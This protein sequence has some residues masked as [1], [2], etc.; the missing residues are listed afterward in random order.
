MKKNNRAAR[1]ACFLIPCFDRRSLPH[2]HVKFSYLKFWRQRELAAVNL[3]LFPLHE[4]SSYQTSE[5]AAHL[6]CTTWSTWNNRKRLNLTQS[7][8]LMW[9]FCC[10]CRRS[11]L[12]SLVKS[13]CTLSWWKYLPLLLW[14]LSCKGCLKLHQRGIETWQVGNKLRFSLQNAIF[15]FKTKLSISYGAR[16]VISIKSWLYNIFAT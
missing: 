15:R 11:F 14:K 2:D 5:S 10:S 13:V 16:L 1:A 8:I 7:S 3:S 4:S 12:N 6:F 9:R